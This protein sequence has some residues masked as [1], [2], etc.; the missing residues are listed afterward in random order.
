MKILLALI[1]KETKEIIRDPVTLGT[2]VFLPLVLL[3][4]FGYAISL[5]IDE[6]Q[7]AVYDQDKSQDSTGL[8]D[9]FTKSG[10]FELNYDLGSAEDADR[11]LDRG[12]STIV[13]VIPPDF[14]KQILAGRKTNIQLLIDG[15][16]SSKALIISNYATA[17]VNEYS[18]QLMELNLAGR[19]LVL[20]TPVKVVPRVW[21][22]PPMSSVNYIVPGLF[23]VL[24]MAFPPILTALSIVREKE[25]GTIEQIY[26]S[27]IRP[28]VFILGK[29]IPYGA[30]A[31]GEMLLILATGTLWFGIPFEGSVFLLIAISLI[32]VLCTVSI[33]LFVSTITKTQLAAV[34]LS[35]IIALMPSFLFSGFLFPITSMPYMLQLYTYVFPARYFNDISRDIFLKGAGIEYLWSNILL[36]IIYTIVLF[37]I[38]SLRFKKKIA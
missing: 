37:Y 34:L 21:Y 20:D 8:I 35:L 16:F 15:T 13:V 36:L 32:Y 33:G 1:K 26:V 14:S 9:A 28:F 10:Y 5:D 18:K 6:I 3:F 25:R 27:P 24:L 22:N 11:V 7:M 19:E 30:I 4:L 17:V 12:Q 23:A 29:I 38:T 2:A 31:F